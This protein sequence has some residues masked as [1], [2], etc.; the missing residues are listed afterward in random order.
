MF[1]RRVFGA[2]RV[3]SLG[4]GLLILAM[5]IGSLP[6]AVVAQTAVIDTFA[7]NGTAGYSG[8]GMA[9]VTASL[10]YPISVAVDTEGNVYIADVN[11]H[12]IRRVR[13][14]G[15]I[16]TF[17]G[18]GSP[19]FSG[20]GGP[21][22]AAQLNAPRGVAVDG[23][24]NVYIA[25]TSNY[26][27]RKVGTDGAITTFAGNGVGT[28]AGDGGPATA[29]SL[30]WPLGSV[31]F[32]GAGNVYIA[33]HKNHR[34]RRVDAAGIITTFAGNGVGTYSGDGGLATEASLRY[35]IDLAMDDTGNLYI[36][37]YN[38]ERIRRVSPDG[39]ITT[40]AGTGVAGYLGDGG[41]ATDARLYRP[42][43]VDLD[44]AGSL[45]IADQFNHRIRRV[46][47]DG[48]IGTV[49]GTGT[50]GFSGDGGDATAALLNQPL[51][52]AIGPEAEIY[53]VDRWNERI[54]RVSGGPAIQLSPTALAFGET[55]VGAVSEKTL[56][57]LNTGG[58]AVFVTAITIGGP[59]APEFSV[60]PTVGEIAPGTNL[61]VT[62]AF[63]P[64]S[65]GPKS[66]TMSI[67]HSAPGSPSSVTLS[68]T[69]VVPGS[70]AIINTF[71]GNGVAGYSGDG[72]AA[73]A[74]SLNYP[75]SVGVDAEGNVYI[76]DVNNHRIRRVRVDGIIT[77]FA[78]TG[79]PGFSGD[80][81]PA[82]AAQLNAPRGVAVDGAGNVYIA[83]T[84]NYRIRKVGTDGAITT[85]AGNGVG[86]YAG[87]G[88]PATAASL[89]WPLGS[90]AFDGAGNVYIADHKNHRIR[91]VDAAGIIT[92]FAGN[93]VGTYSG[94]GGLATE[95]SLRYPI[96]LAM[97]DTGNL[98]IADYNNERIRRVSP[99]GIITTYA[100]TGVAGY[101]GDGGPATD[102]RLYRP[103]GVDLDTA[104]SLYI[105]DQFN[106]RIRRVT[107][108]G[109]IGTVAGTGTAGFSG[110]GGDATAA[111]LNQ[112]LDV[113]IGPEAE[114][115]IVDRWN[116]RIRRV[117]GGPAI[118]LS[119]TAL[120]FG[121]TAVGAVSE[122][123]LTILNTGGSAV[124]V[125]AITIGGPD[126]PEFSVNPTVGEIAPGTN[127]PVTVAFTPTSAGPKSATMSIDH[128]APGSPSSVNLSG[129]GVFLNS[130]P[131]AVD[132]AYSVDKNS[133]LEVPAPGVLGNDTDA[134]GD[135]LSA[136]L[137]SDVAEGA[138]VLGA[139]GS[140]TYTPD[141]DFAGTDQFT[142]R[143]SDG[144]AHSAVLF[145]DTF[146]RPANGDIDASSEGM[147]GS[148]APLAYQEQETAAISSGTLT[149]NGWTSD[150]VPQHDFADDPIVAA[151]GFVLEFDCNPPDSVN[152]IGLA[153]WVGVA[154]GMTE[155][156]AEAG[157]F[158]IEQRNNAFG[159]VLRGSVGDYP[160][161]Y[162]TFHAD[163]NADQDSGVVYDNDPTAQ[164]WYHLK[165]TATA[166]SGQSV[167]TPGHK[168][169]VLV[170]ITGDLDG[171]QSLPSLDTYTMSYTFDWVSTSN[172]ITLESLLAGAVDNLCIRTLDS[173]GSLAMVTITVNAVNDAPVAA[174]DAYDVDEDHTLTVDA[175]GVL[176]NDTDMPGDT[177]TAILV[178]DVSHGTLTLSADGSFS[179]TPGEN[180]N[181]VDSFTYKSQDPS[182][183]ESN[184]A[185][186][187]LTVN[188]VN[189]PPAVGPISGPVDPVPVSA[190]VDVF[191]EFT[192]PDVDDIHT[193]EWDWGDGCTS[194]G[195]VQ[196]E[197]VS[198]SASGNYAYCAPGVYTVTLTVTDAAGASDQSILQYIVVY[199]PEG[200]FVTGGGWIQSPVGAY[201]PAPTITGKANFGFV[202]KYKAGASVPT[203]ETQFKFRAA[204]F[205]FHSTEYQWLVVAGPHAKFKGSGTINDEGDYG[206]MLTATDGQVSGGGDVDTFRIKIWDKAVEDIVYDNKMGEADDSDAG[207]EIG[208]G[209]IV[210]HKED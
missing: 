115:Y 194:A 1:L 160:G 182:L 165:L 148:V 72:G 130:P 102:A 96:D 65:A 120:A 63:T 208:G 68:G 43:G 191:A 127:L 192:D 201:T 109:L 177:L 202:S 53:I 30:N 150:A 97:D 81:G 141:A 181:G 117:S 210:V 56:T 155:A 125:T 196:E 169:T 51:D 39:I 22:T 149:L 104:G 62:V 73:V 4:L 99:D 28:Y 198:G 121:E 38:N 80:G 180:F 85:F 204:D 40:Y 184:V 154:F 84:S 106:H 78:G 114:I 129:T 12:R 199:D 151:D 103:H 137:V 110:D 162:A 189:D 140:F 119:P 124:F 195:D 116:E 17:A 44:T 25:D 37:D 83:D 157:S 55:A 170:E 135:T 183:A 178:T 118:Q 31:A 67:D 188:Q 41:P 164:E 88:G 123:T 66:A 82:T 209:S 79:S 74:A 92:T 152:E 21:A 197:N 35:P 77:T 47:P 138:L 101:L 34:I 107:P 6:R 61:P 122:K 2:R 100:G 167:F 60:N 131:V 186:V 203:G 27:I 19:G 134:D 153:N 171:D 64:T 205:S 45:Y 10:N 143:A 18:T 166:D 158:R 159:I 126:A 144:A 23:A 54:R 206:F 172:Y 11:N 98:Y 48:L 200:G 86:T 190:G 8:D 57:I 16:T 108:D 26:R 173:A 111:L 142:Y 29:A 49:A 14:D 24:G 185:T 113:A 52:V 174:D 75:I 168:A 87:D 176:S 76:A 163:A 71:A 89:N 128:S 58:S 20:D 179:Y 90:V 139:D 156:E 7:G 50:A 36:A 175:P 42:H 187:M 93:G 94:D 70:V 15:I 95:A 112:P 13:V 193:A 207:T 136:A 69:G 145:S 32:D 59:D 147:G 132:D 146:E 46:T 33:D 105:A 5:L 9:A 161:H 3:N 91:R 133:V